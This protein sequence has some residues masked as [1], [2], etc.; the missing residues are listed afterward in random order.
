MTPVPAKEAPSRPPISVTRQTLALGRP[1]TE[2]W[3]RKHFPLLHQSRPKES[4]RL[5]QLKKEKEMT[6]RFMYLPA[7]RPLQ[8]N[9]QM[10]IKFLQYRQ[11]F[12]P[13]V[14]QR[15]TNTA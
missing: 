7:G 5:L 6:P 14:R 11:Q 10:R 1:Q 3:S 8:L 12:V 4:N 15:A 9:R 13:C 2:A